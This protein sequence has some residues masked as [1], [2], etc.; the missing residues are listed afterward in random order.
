M[1]GWP[2]SLRG[3]TVAF[4]ILFL[5]V[6]VLA[7][8]G[9]FFTN[10]A[11]IDDLV[12]RRIEA[13]SDTL[14]R[15][16]AEPDR[17][18]LDQAELERRIRDLGARRATG[19]LGV[20][21]T[22]ARGRRIAGNAALDRPL[23]LGFSALGRQD[24]IEGL[25]A[26]RMFVRE[27][28]GGM[29]LAIFA[30]TEP[31]DHYFAARRRIY[32][33]GFG[34]IVVVVLGGLLLF[35]RLIGERIEQMRRTVDSIIDGDLSQRVPLTGDDGEFDHQAAA[36]NRMLDRIEALMGEIRNVSNDISHELRTPLARLRN[37]LASLQRRS[38][39]APIHQALTQATEQA[40]DLLEMFGAMLR[41]AEIESGSRR[42]GF[43]ST[44]LQAIVEDVAETIRPAAEEAGRT[45]AIGRCDEGVLMADPQLL[46]Q[47]LLNLVENGVN[48]APEGRRIEISA[49]RSAD[50]F[51]L[52]VRDDGPGIPPDQHALVLRRFGRLERSRRQ[53]GHGLGLPLADAI[54]RLHGGTLALEDAAPGLR[55]VV[56]LPV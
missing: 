16:G 15:Q 7:G 13:E 22:D 4:L 55:V 34:A 20:I 50:R 6:T 47:M 25:S 10:L 53:S 40:D 39:A 38:S 9:T 8:A 48:H 5:A 23:P 14:L 12:D 27:I 51:V 29:R 54:A 21:L 32:L 33:V 19:D 1:I 18:G 11:T 42:V 56:T 43:R 3:L 31:I 52:T 44:M 41:I 49:I 17:S 2:K 35:R 24:G 46:S 30:E 36:F 28:D 26:G 45:I 37:E